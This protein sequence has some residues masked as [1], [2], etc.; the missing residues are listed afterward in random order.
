MLIL[1]INRPGV[2]TAMQMIDRLTVRPAAQMPDV[3]S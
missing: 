2:L 1:L 3:R